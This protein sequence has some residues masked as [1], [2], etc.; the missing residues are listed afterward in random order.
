MSKLDLISNESND[1]FKLKSSLGDVGYVAKVVNSLESYVDIKL[2]AAQLDALNATPVTVIAAPGANKFINVTK[3]V[4][5][6]DFNSAAYAGTSETLAIRY[7]NGSGDI[8]CSFTEA[9]FVEASAD[10]YESPDMIQVFPVVNSPVVAHATADF[11][12][13]DSPIYLRI[14]YSIVD[15]TDLGSTV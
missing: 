9:T 5:F 7:T 6:L 8:I 2:T 13:G 4:G 12:T 3:V 15:L 10:A 14:W 1:V 11:T